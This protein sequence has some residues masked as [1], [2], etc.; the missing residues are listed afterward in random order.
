MSNS[1][2]NLDSHLNHIIIIPLFTLFTAFDLKFCFDINSANLLFYC[3]YLPSISLLIPLFL[4]FHN[5]ILWEFLV[6]STFYKLISK[7]TGEIFLTHYFKYLLYF[8]DSFLFLFRF[9]ILAELIKFS[10]N[11]APLPTHAHTHIHIST[12]TMIL[13]FHKS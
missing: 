4:S 13:K 7:L 8:V 3:L 11:I 9:F 6:E 5:F 1:K 2:E 12:T 10:F